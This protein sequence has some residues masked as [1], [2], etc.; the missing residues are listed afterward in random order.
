[1]SPAP[2]S[3][4]TQSVEQLLEAALSLDAEE[5][6]RF[7]A[8]PLLTAAARR[9]RRMDIRD[10]ALVKLWREHF[11]DLKCTPAAEQIA[12]LMLDPPPAGTRLGDSVHAIPDLN[13][14]APISKRHL[15]DLLK[16]WRGW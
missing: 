6:A 12:R 11:G 2:Q 3:A 13:G 1:M 14:E 8:H 7:L 16:G 9:Q 5:L 15:I 10:A 4:E